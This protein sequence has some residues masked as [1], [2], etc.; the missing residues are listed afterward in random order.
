MEKLYILTG[1]CQPYWIIKDRLDAEARR[2]SMF[3][4]SNSNLSNFMNPIKSV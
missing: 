4:N 1:D 3:N 2:K